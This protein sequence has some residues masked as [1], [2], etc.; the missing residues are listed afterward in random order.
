MKWS[1]SVVSNSL[2][3]V[4]CS[5][6]SPSIHGILQARIPEWVAISFS[7]GYSRPRDQTQ[8]SHI[9]GARL[10]HL[11]AMQEARVRFLG[12][13]YPLEKEMAIHSS[14]LVWKI[15]WTEEPDRLQSM[16]S[17]R[18][19]PDWATSL[20]S[21]PEPVTVP[22]GEEEVES[23]LWEKY[24]SW[25]FQWSEGVRAGLRDSN[26][27]AGCYRKQLRADFCWALRML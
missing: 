26:L 5:P 27:T 12:R 1:R 17:Q 21:L 15:S 10:K 7:R 22:Q 8:V 19:R 24:A 13:E 4:D 3:P 23:L 2:R 16:G 9:G 25:C 20:H 18:V 14:T 11:P 6:P